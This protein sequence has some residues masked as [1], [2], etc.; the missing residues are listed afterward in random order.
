MIADMNTNKKTFTSSNGI[1]VFITQSYV[2]VPKESRLNSTLS[3]KR[4]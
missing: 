4:F 3:I 2:A 1:S